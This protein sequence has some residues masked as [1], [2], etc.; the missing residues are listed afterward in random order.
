[1]SRYR[2]SSRFTGSIRELGN[3]KLAILHYVGRKRFAIYRFCLG[4]WDCDLFTLKVI[5]DRIAATY[6]L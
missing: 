5:D 2:K 1:V 6:R 3:R 4:D